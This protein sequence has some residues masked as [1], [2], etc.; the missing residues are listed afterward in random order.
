MTDIWA[1]T[2]NKWNRILGRRN[3][4][5]ATIYLSI[6]YLTFIVHVVGVK[7]HLLRVTQIEL[8]HL[9]S[10]ATFLSGWIFFFSDPV[11]NYAIINFFDYHYWYFYRIEL[12]EYDSLSLDSQIASKEV[13]PQ[14]SNISLCKRKPILSNVCQYWE[15][16]I[17]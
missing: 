2:W 13:I 7:L 8:I 11:I 9:T 1:K 15:V 4:K 5:Q 14:Y 16:P 6:I 12:Q 10:L 3:D 17:N